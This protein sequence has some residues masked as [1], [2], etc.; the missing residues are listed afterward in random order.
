[1]DL[2]IIQLVRYHWF[3]HKKYLGS[4]KMY[5]RI[6]YHIDI[7]IFYVNYRRQDCQVITVKLN[8]NFLGVLNIHGR[9]NIEPNSNVV[10]LTVWKGRADNP[11]P[12][13]VGTLYILSYLQIIKSKPHQLKYFI[14]HNNKSK[15]ILIMYRA[16]SSNTC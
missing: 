13:L 10:Y 3:V 7:Y 5:A 2:H 1:M 8:Q 11:Y 4:I 6:S 14:I 16:F 12:I 15:N 9:S